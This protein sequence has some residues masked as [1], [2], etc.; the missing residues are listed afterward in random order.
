MG[1]PGDNEPY[2]RTF[3][4]RIKDSFQLRHI[5]GLL[6]GEIAGFLYYYFVTCQSE[7]CGMK[8]NPLYY[9]VLGVLLGYLVGDFL[10]SKN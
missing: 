4:E 9:I 3:K 8:S 10:K 5:I 1:I 2:K 7:T 6:I